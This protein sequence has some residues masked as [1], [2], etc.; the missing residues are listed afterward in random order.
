MYF[1]RLSCNLKLKDTLQLEHNFYSKK[2]FLIIKVNA[3]VF[4]VVTNNK[5]SLWESVCQVLVPFSYCYVI[6][7]LNPWLTL[8]VFMVLPYL[9]KYT[10][11]CLKLYW[12]SYFLDTRK[13]NKNSNTLTSQT[14]TIPSITYN[15]S[16]N[17]SL[18][19][20]CIAYIRI[21]CLT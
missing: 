15:Y 20:W 21:G 19:L 12:S 16:F 3:Y 17:N 10:F 5:H 1:S 11:L 18:C 9:D 6:H 13:L 8:Y 2:C 4:G 14:L 7:T